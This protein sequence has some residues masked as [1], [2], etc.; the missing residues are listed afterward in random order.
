MNLKVLKNKNLVLVI[1]GQFVSGF[2]TFMQGFALSLYVLKKTGSATLFASVLVV[3]VIP[4]ILL[5]PFAGVI[6]D[7]FSRKKMIVIMD[8]LSALTVAAFA[9][10]YVINGE[11][12]LLSIYILAI[13]LTVISSFFTP[14]M[15]AIIPDIVPKK[16][17]ADANSIRMIP[18][19]VLNLLSPLAAGVL[20]GVFGLLPIMLINSISFF[21]SAISEMFIRIKKES[22]LHEENR[23]PYF[24]S[25]KQGLKFIKTLPEIIVMTCIA[26][27]ANF[28]LAPVFSVALPIVLL[29]DFGVSEQLYGLFNSLT[30]IGML[31]API[32]A[33]K[34]IKKYHYSKLVW[35]ILTFDGILAVIVAVLSINGI[36]PDVMINYISMV[37]IIN[38]LLI[39]VIWVNLAISTAMQLLVR[40]D[41]M[42]R[43]SSVLSTFAMIASPLGVALMGYLLEIGESYIILGA[44]S[45][46]LIIVGLLAKVGFASLERKGKM[47][48]TLGLDIQEEGI[49]E[50][51]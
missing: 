20:F 22:I 6:A 40:R 44:Y 2:G 28:A 7:R 50:N 39:T 9:V 31:I 48:I 4:R 1:L 23:E 45:V 18:E 5:T 16:E 19:S 3:S 24:E 43:V 30:T 15:S 41:M 12:N 26:V 8:F 37:V 17:L 34:I 38:V 27:V 33:A 10:V 36:F 46:L 51:A 25:M 14:S 13:L 49:P 21:A 29:Q 11:L 47:D 42:G 35:T 32:F